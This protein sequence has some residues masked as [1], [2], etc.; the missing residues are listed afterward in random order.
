[1]IRL[2]FKP[3]ELI[4]VET[5][6]VQGKIKGKGWICRYIKRTKQVGANDEPIVKVH[7]LKRKRPI[8]VSMDDCYH[9][10]PEHYERQRGPKHQHA[11]P[12]SI[13]ENSDAA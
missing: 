9:L 4:F 1:M 13:G 10:K 6:T 3:N 8:L 2:P 5:P 12:E 7:I 11:E